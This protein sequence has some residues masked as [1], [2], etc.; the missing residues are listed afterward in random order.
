MT[1]ANP[2]A[3]SVQEDDVSASSTP[4]QS[5]ELPPATDFEERIYIGGLDPLR[6]KAMDVLQRIK[7]IPG[8]EITGSSLEQQQRQ[9]SASS[10]TPYS[11]SSDSNDDDHDYYNQNPKN[12]RFFHIVVKTQ[13]PG[14]TAL[15]TISKN[16]HN[17]KWKGCRLIVQT[18]RPHFLKRLDEERT[19]L[20]QKKGELVSKDP[21]TV[22]ADDGE[23]NNQNHRLPRRLRIRQR[24]GDEA[25]HVDTKPCE[26]NDWS[27]LTNAL[28]RMQKRR[29]KAQDKHTKSSSR[30]HYD[31]DDNIIAASSS[32]SQSMAFLNR[33][34]HIRFHDD[35][36]ID[37]T[38]V[39]YNSVAS[40]SSS[41]ESS[42]T[43]STS[44]SDDMIQPSSNDVVENNSPYNWSD[45]NGE[46]DDGD[47]SSVQEHQQQQFI[48][49]F[50][51]S[52]SVSSK[53]SVVTSNSDDDSGGGGDAGEGSRR[54]TG[55]QKDGK[56]ER[57]DVDVPSNQRYQWSSDEEEDDDRNADRKSKMKDA[58]VALRAMAAK[59]FNA[60]DE[61][62][63]GGNIMNEDE[64]VEDSDDNSEQCQQLSQPVEETT[65]NA[66]GI[67]QDV[68]SNLNI[69]SS[70]FPGIG[71]VKPASVA[72][73]DE[74]DKKI[75]SGPT[76]AEKSGCQP[77][78]SA[79]SQSGWGTD[80]L[81]LR[82]DPTKVS[83]QKFVVDEVGQDSSAS[84]DDNNDPERSDDPGDSDNDRSSS[85]SKSSDSEVKKDTNSV[86]IDA[87]A[88]KEHLYEQGKLED[89]FRQARD[90]WN[91]PSTSY[92][93]Q[94]GQ[95]ATSKTQK[96]SSS[97]SFSFERSNSFP[98]QDSSMAKT[99]PNQNTGF[100]FSFSVPVGKKVVGSNES[101]ASVE[102]RGGAT[103]SLLL[104]EDHL[105][106]V[107]GS[108]ADQAVCRRGLIFPEDDLNSY[109]SMFFY[110][111]DGKRMMEDPD[112]FRHDES[113][114]EKW[115]KERHALTL[116][117]KRKRKHVVARIQKRKKFR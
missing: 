18:A 35:N 13:V 37:R 59:V 103:P 56:T 6:L 22:V 45:D 15:E 4:S 112:G 28:S 73:H 14:K 41:E 78:A 20:Q 116:D 70:L 76:M 97:F 9:P 34:V 99:A 101:L 81:M 21:S 88:P 80:G 100:S 107:E 63:S 32:S 53:E 57:N 106:Q 7:L 90:A 67:E 82:Y 11:A 96:A 74:H 42:S 108:T 68:E 79:S 85:Q 72:D 86:T 109:V 98:R 77:D 31:K 43:S 39:A 113:V 104:G 62:A 12:K 17:V 1:I 75:V 10:A 65:K 40:S 44:N 36:D 38:D 111:N 64:E 94:D 25:Y 87:D 33:G 29:E 48:G 54:T 92:K 2:A 26:V 114:K 71:N 60:N 115:N 30:N 46:N 66:D 24:Y 3:E 102:G 8:I 93:S 117:W 110:M 84:G 83:A 16:Y 95:A 23:T 91:T 49:D 50:E 52:A 27:Q 55:G 19:K 69:L 47:G 58:R 51:A 105:E 61:F 5:S 89:V